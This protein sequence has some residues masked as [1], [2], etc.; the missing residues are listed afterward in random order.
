MNFKKR[1]SK[2]D[3]LIDLAP[4]MDVVF[5]L[6][7]FFMVTASFVTS[8]GIKIDLPQASSKDVVSKNKD[9]T[10]LVRYNQDIMLDNEIVTMLDLKKRLVNRAVAL[11]EENPLV[12]IKADTGV[13]HGRVVEVMDIAREA[14]L[15]QL[16]I[17]TK[18]KG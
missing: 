9:I 16:A 8:P 7:I 1:N 18:P 12:I 11:K 15:H 17:A 6:L 3:V 13:T 2:S 5:M 14:G 10:I 4:F